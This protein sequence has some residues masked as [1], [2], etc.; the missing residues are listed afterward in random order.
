MPIV[1]KALFFSQQRAIVKIMKRERGFTLIE[2]MIAIAIVAIALTLAIPS[3]T[4]VIK[5]NRLITQINELVAHLS[6]ARSEAIKRGS[7]IS[8]C[9]SADQAACGG[10]WNTGWITFLDINGNG[11]FDNATDAILRI[12]EGFDGSNTLDGS[13]AVSTSASYLGSGFTNLAANATF[14]L[15]DDRGA[16]EGRQ[17]TISSTGRVS[18][19]T[20]PAS[21][22]P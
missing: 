2:L 9:A 19:T 14:S 16:T 21:C 1:T 18:T 10:A 12:H 4:T 17:L 6:Y 15:C 8:V 7:V 22:T 5:N 3:F 11:D 13:A 20:S